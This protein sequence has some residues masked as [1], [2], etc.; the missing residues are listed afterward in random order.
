[1]N[2][3]EEA[4]LKKCVE[5]TSLLTK[6]TKAIEPLT[7]RCP[8]GH[9]RITTTNSKSSHI[10]RECTPGQSTKKS[11]SYVTK[12][13]LAA[14]LE[15][16]EAYKGALDKLLARNLECGHEYLV[17]PSLIFSGRTVLCPICKKSYNFEEELLA[18]NLVLASEYVDRKTNVDVTKN[19]C[20]HTYSINP[21][22]FLYDGIGKSCQ[23]CS[24]KGCKGT[25]T[26]DRF[27]TKL[28]ES[29]ISIEEPPRDITEYVLAHNDNCGHEYL[30]QPQN[31][32]QQDSGIV[33]RICEPI[34]STSR[35]ATEWLNSLNVPT[36]EWNVPNSR[37]RADGYD[38]ETNT[39]YEF[40]GDF[41]HGNPK[42]FNP[43]DTNPRAKV[44]YKEL[45][46]KTLEKINFYET[47]G[48]NL[49]QI[50]ESAYN[51]K[52]Q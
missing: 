45:Y 6:Y 38:P 21:G 20:G 16:L 31:L 40:W 34:S 36:R 50:W 29:N 7:V 30:I 18:N 17:N 19:D 41:W 22:H 42:K 28:I 12:T 13:F 24:A 49:V 43:E 27:F 44:S 51:G 32:V 25:S 33:C 47:N 5:G 23:I 39:V 4:F 15:K 37:Y 26:M 48:Y 46:D 9:V 52:E 10:C 2:I 1:M 8:E 14:G 35:I 3:Y 11:A